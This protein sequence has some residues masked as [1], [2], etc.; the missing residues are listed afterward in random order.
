MPAA[1]GAAPV[2][3]PGAKQSV[4]EI[5]ASIIEIGTSNAK[6]LEEEIAGARTAKKNAAR[7]LDVC[8]VVALLCLVLR[9]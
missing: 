6:Q 1:G 9:A 4:E 5:L 8:V 7:D 3:Q 2:L